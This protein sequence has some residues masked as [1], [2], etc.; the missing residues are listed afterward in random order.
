M[1]NCSFFQ[2]TPRDYIK[3]HDSF[4]KAVR[5][6]FRCRMTDDRGQRSEVRG[7]RTDDR[8]QMTEDRGQISALPP[9]KQTAGQIARRNCADLVFKMRVTEC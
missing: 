2:F 4:G 3:T 8:G 9:A 6:G 1:V 7:Q 5:G